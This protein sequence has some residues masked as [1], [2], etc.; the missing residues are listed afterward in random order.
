MLYQWNVV[1]LKSALRTRGIPVTGLKSELIGRVIHAV[2]MPPD[3]MLA[4]ALEVI[5]RRG[6]RPDIE[7]ILSET[8]LGAWIAGEP[9]RNDQPRCAE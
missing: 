4:E 3:E 2:R 5:R 6:A 1:Q 7:A 8:S 9:S